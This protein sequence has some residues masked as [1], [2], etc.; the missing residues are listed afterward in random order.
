MKLTGV[1]EFRKGTKMADFNQN[2]M[3][4][5]VV[6]G[7]EVELDMGTRGKCPSFANISTLS[8]GY[9]KCSK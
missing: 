8:L 3:I 6:S 9:K 4:S 7:L 5:G 2:H 1:R